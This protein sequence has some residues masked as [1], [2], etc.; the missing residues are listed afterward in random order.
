MSSQLQVEPLHL[1][2]MRQFPQ[3]VAR[4]CDSYSAKEILR[5]L[6]TVPGFQAA[7]ILTAMTPSVATEVIRVMSDEMV[8]KVLPQARYSLIAALLQRLPEE[9]RE[10]IL[11]KLPDHVSY[12]MK[13]YL[14]YPEDSVGMLMDPIVFALAKDLTVEEAIGQVRAR[15]PRDI[16]EV[17]IIDRNQILVGV[18]LLRDLFL[19]PSG[20][21]LES[22]MRPDLPTIHPLENR[23]QI[24]DIFNEW[25]VVTI[26]VTDLD[27][28]LLGVIRNRDIIQVEKEEA[29]ISLQ[30]MVGASKDERAL[31]PPLFAVRKR[32]PWLEINLLT[33]FL[34]AFVVGLFENTIATYTALAVLLPVVAGQSGNTGA[35][36]LAVVMRGLALR[37]IRPRQWLKVTT[38]E[39][40]VAFLNGLAVAVTTAAAVYV[41]STSWGLTTVIG[42]SMVLSMV[43]AGFSG[44]II[45]IILRALKQDPAQSSSIILTTVTDVAGFFSFL[46]LATIFSNWLGS[47]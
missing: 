3:E 38:K 26:P 34:A 10:S 41:W 23:D 4:I 37:D 5:V 30:T 18:I 11:K 27:G 44:A 36:A 12:E 15:A 13:A 42:I 1:V 39:T 25:K 43:I 46:G 17:Y 35:Q 7:Q 32:L 31:S 22:L 40:Y 28:H 16:H 33:A 6:Q 14:E 2:F 47:A 24:V 9:E 19:A 45:P 29:T 8:Q 21:R 20:D